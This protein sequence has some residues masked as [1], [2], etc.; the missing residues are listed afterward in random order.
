[1]ADV[2]KIAGE[3]LETALGAGYMGAEA[4][5]DAAKN[6]DAR[7]LELLE[8][9]LNESL[10]PV[11]E[12][13]TG[14]EEVSVASSH[15]STVRYHPMSSTMYITFVNGKEY[16][17]PGIEESTFRELINAPSPGSYFWANIRSRK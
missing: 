11:G 4:L 8:S 2:S 13:L 12:I 10:G 5:F 6:F 16:F 3:L 7:A 9:A 14:V 15:L 1:V 17:F